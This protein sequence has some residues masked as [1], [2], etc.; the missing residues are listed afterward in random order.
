MD[1]A[2]RRLVRRLDRGHQ[3]NVADNI[4]NAFPGFTDLRRYQ[5]Y[6]TNIGTTNGW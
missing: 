3:Q 5:A 2:G 6:P 1:V 4:R